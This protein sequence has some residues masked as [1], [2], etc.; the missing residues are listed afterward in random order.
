MT[1]RTFDLLI[2]VCTTIGLASNAL[3]TLNIFDPKLHHRSRILKF[4][5]GGGKKV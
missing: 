1:R 3:A 4:G 2:V 5:S